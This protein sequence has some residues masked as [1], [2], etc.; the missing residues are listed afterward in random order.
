MPRDPRHVAPGRRGVWR[1]IL[2]RGAAFGIGLGATVL[3]GCGD[4]NRPSVPVALNS[5]YTDEQPALSGDGRYLAFVSN[6]DGTRSILLYDLR[7]E[8]FAKLPQINRDD[9]VAES[10]SLSY[11]GRYLVYLASDRG[12][13]EIELYDRITRRTQVLTGAYR[14]WVRNPRISPDGRYIVFET[15]RRGQWDIETIDRGPNIELDRPDGR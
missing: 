7:R 9:A 3:S 5:Y 12:R 2:R 15:G 8:Q 13:P 14:G 11:T 10:P 1:S 6:R 4:R